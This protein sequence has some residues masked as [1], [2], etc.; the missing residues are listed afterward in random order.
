M[1][2]VVLKEHVFDVGQS[3]LDCR[4]LR[5][6]IDTIGIVF[7]HLLKPSDLP[8]QEFEAADNLDLI[9]SVHVFHALN[10][11]PPGGYMQAQQKTTCVG[12]NLLNTLSP[13]AALVKKSHS[14]IVN[15]ADAELH[16]RE[17]KPHTAFFN[18][19]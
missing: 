10:F 12:E 14:D 6:D 4:S 1:P 3:L 9:G 5:D 8:F 7:H 17:K 11:I 16:K 13:K 18:S 2:E 19:H 15:G